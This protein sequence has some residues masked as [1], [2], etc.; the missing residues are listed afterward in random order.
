MQRAVLRRALR[1]TEMEICLHVKSVEEVQI[2][3]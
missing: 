1:I 2:S 3:K